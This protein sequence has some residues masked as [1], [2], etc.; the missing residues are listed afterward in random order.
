MTLLIIFFFVF[1][2]CAFNVSLEAVGPAVPVPPPLTITAGF[3][4]ICRNGYG[5]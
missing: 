5:T 2:L 1:L 4:T 3:Y